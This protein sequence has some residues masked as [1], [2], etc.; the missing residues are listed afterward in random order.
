MN[1][2]HPTLALT[3]H[4]QLRLLGQAD[5]PPLPPRLAERLGSAAYMCKHVAAVLYGIGACFD[6]QPELLFTL[7]QVDA[8]ELLSKAG[9]GLATAAGSSARTLA[10]D[11]VGALFGLEMD[12][13]TAAPAAARPRTKP[14]RTVSKPTAH[15]P[16]PPDTAAIIAREL[17][18]QTAQ[19]TGLRPQRRGAASPPGPAL[20]VRD[21]FARLAQ[22]LR[23]AGALDNAT[24]RTVTG[25]HAAAVRPLLRRLV[26]EGL[27]RITGQKRGTR[28]VARTS[29][30]SQKPGR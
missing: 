12:A 28:Y 1:D 3:P 13:E 5:A 8:A 30:R 4:G 24:A 26:E 21:P 2:P 15:K 25:L 19:A 29:A 9:A 16:K 23:R 6:Q 7:R 14:G 20:R 18:R 17:A 22:E 10:T 27:A 11:D